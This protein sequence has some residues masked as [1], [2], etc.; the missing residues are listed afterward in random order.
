PSKIVTK[1]DKLH[2]KTTIRFITPIAINGLAVSKPV[3]RHL[4]LDIARRLEDCREHSFSDR[5]NILWCDERC[6]DVDLCKFRL[7]VCEQIFVA[8]TFCDLKI[9]FHT[10]DHQQLF[11][12]LW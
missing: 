10:G 5:E 9:F 2:S 12:L 3:K 8:K 1:L 4:D 11:V 7:P 6:F